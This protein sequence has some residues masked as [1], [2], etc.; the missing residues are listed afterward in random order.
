ML[1]WRTSRW[2][3][4][5]GVQAAPESHVVLPSIRSAVVWDLASFLPLLIS[6]FVR[7]ITTPQLQLDEHFNQDVL[8]ISFEWIAG[9]VLRAFSGI[10]GFI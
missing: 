7:P 1:H 9:V 10:I 5:R 6:V 2:G 8:V 4:S 3:W